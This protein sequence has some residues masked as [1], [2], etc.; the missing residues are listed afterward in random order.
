[1]FLPIFAMPIFTG[2]QLPML[3]PIFA[4]HWKAMSYGDL[5]TNHS[6]I[7]DKYRSLYMRVLSHK[8]QIFAIKLIIINAHFDKQT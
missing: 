2:V 3:I 4:G 6:C 1:V 5:Q 8:M 7:I